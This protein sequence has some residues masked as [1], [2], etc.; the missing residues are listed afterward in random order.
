MILPRQPVAARLFLTGATLGPLIDSLHNQ[1]LLK[2][3]IA[4][5][6]LDFSDQVSFHSSW[7]VLPLLGVAYIILG[8][9]LPQGIQRVIDTISSTDSATKTAK[10][11]LTLRAL[12]AVLTTAAIV[13]FSGYLIDDSSINMINT[14]A[15]DNT[16]SAEQNLLFLLTL[17][18]T[19]WSFLDSTMSGLL[20]A[21]LAAIIGPVS[22]VPFV[23]SGF[24]EYLDSDALY[25]PLGLDV[26]LH[27]LTGPCYFA[28]T[29][30][31]I[32]LGRW[33]DSWDDTTDSQGSADMDTAPSLT[34]PPTTHHSDSSPL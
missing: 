17:A 32:A 27:S 29:M 18:I 12:L 30:D 26:N 22:E 28:V 16:S 33:F 2:Y 8:W 24:W 5:I 15:F 20:A 25:Q 14:A 9:I 13:R 11:T 3:N 4:N 6:E 10:T 34:S 31:A 23:A 1:L 7:V 21:S 19:Q